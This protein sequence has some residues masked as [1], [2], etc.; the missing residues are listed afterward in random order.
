MEY[1]S[2]YSCTIVGDWPRAKNR[3]LIKD[4]QKLIFM[5]AMSDPLT[6]YHFVR[7][8]GLTG[9]GYMC[10]TLPPGLLQ[11]PSVGFEDFDF[12]VSA[13]DLHRRRG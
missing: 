7:F 13:G 9:P 8:C 11:S 6:R 2:R 5:S 12:A 10:R 4:F 3:E 1:S